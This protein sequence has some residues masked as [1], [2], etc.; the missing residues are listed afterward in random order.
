M[1]VESPDI[2]EQLPLSDLFR[3]RL[4]ASHPTMTWR[5]FGSQD[6]RIFAAVHPSPWKPPDMS[7]RLARSKRLRFAGSLAVA[8]LVAVTSHALAQSA[9]K[10]I[11]IPLIGC[12]SDGQM[13]PVAAPASGGKTPRIPQDFAGSLAYYTS[14]AL[15]VIAPRG[16]NCFGLYGSGGAVLLVT[17]ERHDADDLLRSGRQ[18][19]GSAIVLSRVFGST[20]GRFEV[21]KLAA[22]L[23]PVANNFVQ[24]VIDEGIEP[25]IDFQLMPFPADKLTRRSPTAVEYFSP[26]G[27]E[28]LGTE[29]PLAKNGEPISGVVILLPDEEMTAIKLDIRLPTELHDLVSQITEDVLTSKGRP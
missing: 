12:A 24:G 26:G 3:R 4:K 5:I 16:W 25:A 20:S 10:D 23:F 22:R 14:A 19:E 21:A 6:N 18:I 7:D 17:P 8:A 28:G 2:M 9:E 29:G 11:A 15:G 1:Q 27:T 13:G